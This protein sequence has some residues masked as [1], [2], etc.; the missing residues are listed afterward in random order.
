MSTRGS[1]N[2]HTRRHKDMSRRVVGLAL[3]AGFL[4]LTSLAF[5]QTIQELRVQWTTAP[6]LP[7]G[8]SAER[9]GPPA[10]QL[11]SILSRQATRGRLPRQREP[12]LNSDQVVIIARDSNGTIVDWQVVPDPRLVRAEGPGPGG[13]LSGRV[14][15]RERGDFLLTLPNEPGIAR[16]DFYHP[17]WAGTNFDLDLIGGVSLP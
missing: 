7:P 12:E 3:V 11:F 17:R 8:T 2:S 9:I 1:R 13:E 4:A 5:G 14:F 6:P 15:Y 10:A 16:I